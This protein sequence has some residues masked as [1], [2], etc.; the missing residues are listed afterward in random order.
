[1]KGDKAVV[2][3]T[4]NEVVEGAYLQA[5]GKSIPLPRIYANSEAEVPV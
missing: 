2:K 3:N 1:V 5:G 4:L